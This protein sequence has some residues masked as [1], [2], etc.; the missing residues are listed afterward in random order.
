MSMAEDWHDILVV[1]DNVDAG[2]LG[3]NLHQGSLPGEL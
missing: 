3:E 2:H 1:V